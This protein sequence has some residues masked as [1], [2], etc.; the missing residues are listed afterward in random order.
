MSTGQAKQV[1]Y[2]LNGVV[3]DSFGTPVPDPGF[4][5][6]PG[7]T[8][9]TVFDEGVSLGIIDGLNFTGAGVTVSGTGNVLV[10][11]P[12]SSLPLATQGQA[13][14]GIENSAYMSALRVAQAI[15]VQAQNLIIATQAEAEAGVETTHYMTPYLVAKAIAALA[16]GGGSGG[17]SYADN[18]VD[19]G[20]VN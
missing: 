10:N 6:L 1:T 14:A 4:S 3:V 18:Y 15:D 19:L 13:E 5:G 16:T 7:S 8:G 12:G 17:N 2:L 11:I 9:V 20:Y